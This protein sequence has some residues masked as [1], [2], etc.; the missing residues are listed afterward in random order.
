MRNYV[1][2]SN[3]FK[4]QYTVNQRKT[5]SEHILQ[6]YK[7][8]I[9]IIVTLY[10]RELLTACGEKRNQKYLTPKEICMGQLVTIF[11]KRHKLRPDEALYVFVNDNIIVPVTSEIGTVY[12][13]Y[14]DEDGFLYLYISKESVFG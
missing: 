11:R 5:E 12:L 8:R 6:K 7:D 10:D 1:K 2:S 4:N 3:E 9:P 14:K 13:E